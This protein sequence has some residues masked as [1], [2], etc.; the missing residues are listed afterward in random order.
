MGRVVFQPNYVVSRL[1]VLPRTS[2]HTRSETK[3][4]TT[5]PISSYR[6]VSNFVFKQLTNFTNILNNTLVFYCSSEVVP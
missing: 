3:E 4:S 6:I 2:R 1:F 5:E